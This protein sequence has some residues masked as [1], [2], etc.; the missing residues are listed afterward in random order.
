M[1]EEE[2][3]TNHSPDALLRTKALVEKVKF[4]MMTTRTP[5][6]RLLSR[7][8]TTQEMD[9]EGNLWFFAL[10]DSEQTFAFDFD[11]SVNLAFASP[12]NSIFISITGAGTIVK[13]RKQI[14]SLWRS[15]M[16]TWLAEEKM[17]PR[18]CLIKVHPHSAEYWDGPTSKV[19]ELFGIAKAMLTGEPFRPGFEHGKVTVSGTGELKS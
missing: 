15:A 8:M 5:E 11:E 16:G 13:E 3:M 9:E 4:C 12:E 10:D 1:R 18:L 14:E 17:D 7:P 2:A 6:G 19:T